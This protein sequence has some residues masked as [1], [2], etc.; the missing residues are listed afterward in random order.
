M[1]MRPNRT[2]TSPRGVRC[3]RRLATRSPPRDGRAF[4]GSPLLAPYVAS[5]F[6]QTVD[7]DV[8]DRVQGDKQR[9]AD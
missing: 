4:D 8:A 7:S 5:F 3:R 6:E 2:G 1:A 9:A